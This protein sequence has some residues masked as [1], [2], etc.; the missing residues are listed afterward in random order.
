MHIGPPA[1]ALPSCSTDTIFPVCFH[2]ERSGPRRYTTLVRSMVSEV[3]KLC[4]VD[5]G[6]ETLF[7]GSTAVTRQNSVVLIG[8]SAVG[9]KP[10]SLTPSELVPLRRMAPNVEAVE[11]SNR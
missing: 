6:L 2:V 5:G 10:V 9:M 7:A 8:R 3:T 11:I 4:V 1:A